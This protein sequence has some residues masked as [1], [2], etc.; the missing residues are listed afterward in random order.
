M[1][2]LALWLVIINL[3]TFGLYG[4]D[5]KRARS[6]QWRISEKTLLVAALAGGGLG[7]LAGMRVF[8]HKTRKPVFRIL[9]PLSVLVWTLA[10]ILAIQKMTGGA[11]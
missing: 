7:A 8:H 9:V 1:N 3:V 2:Y 6:G 4:L 11:A 10:L 5:K